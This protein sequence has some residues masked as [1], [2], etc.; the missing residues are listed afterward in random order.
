MQRSESVCLPCGFL[1]RTRK[2]QHKTQKWTQAALTRKEEDELFKNILLIQPG[3]QDTEEWLQAKF[4]EV[5]IAT[6]DDDTEEGPHARFGEVGTAIL[7]DA[8]PPCLLPSIPASL[9]GLEETHQRKCNMTEE[10]KAASRGRAAGAGR[11]PH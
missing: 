11:W 9:D 7:D 3:A 1:Q 4:A 8:L 5:G 2:A 10:E 6:R